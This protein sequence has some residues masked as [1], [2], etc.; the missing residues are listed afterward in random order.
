MGRFD[1]A[2]VQK[3]DALVAAAEPSSSARPLTRRISAGIAALT[4]SVAAE[5]PAKS[6]PMA[7][8]EKA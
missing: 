5:A 3:H 6:A 2:A 1:R 7:G 4:G 8:L